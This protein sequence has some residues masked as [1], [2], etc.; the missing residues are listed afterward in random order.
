[1]FHNLIGAGLS[2]VDA[3]RTANRLIGRDGK[4][5]VLYRRTKKEMPCGREEVDVMIEEGITIAELIAPELILQTEKGLDIN[6]SQMVLTEKDSSGRRSPVKIEGSEFKMS[7]DS[8]ITAIGQDTELDFFPGQKLQVDKTT[9][10]TKIE[11]VFAGGDAVR[12][13]DSLINAMADGQNI[14]DRILQRVE[15][16]LD[17]SIKLE[18]K[19]TEEEFQQK[20]A[21]RVSGSVVVG[22]VEARAGELLTTST[23]T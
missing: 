19:F 12:G 11:N 4:V 13:A 14:A 7:F 16:D 15:K 2:A 20:L 1:M 5:T 8:V 21:V 9:M 18:K 3:A 10:Q 17:H 22:L 23:T 6:C